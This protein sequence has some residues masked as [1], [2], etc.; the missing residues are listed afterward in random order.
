M[1]L[2]W[3]IGILGVAV[4]LIGV[5]M[6]LKDNSQ[7]ADRISASAI[8]AMNAPMTTYG[9]RKITD[10]CECCGEHKETK[11]YLE[12]GKT[13]REY[14]KVCADSARADGYVSLQVLNVV[15]PSPKPEQTPASRASEWSGFSEPPEKPRKRA[16]VK[17]GTIITL[18]IVAV[19]LIAV[20]TLTVVF[21]RQIS[22]FIYEKT[23]KCFYHQLSF[24]DNHS[25]TYTQRAGDTK[26]HDITRDFICDRCGKEIIETKKQKHS[27]DYTYSVI[28]RKS[29]EKTHTYKK[30]SLC[31]QC[32]LILEQ[33]DITEGHTEF[34]SNYIYSKA[35]GTSH[36]VRKLI[37]CAFCGVF[38]GEENYTEKHSDYT[39]STGYFGSDSGSHLVRKYSYCGKCGETCGYEDTYEQH[40]FGYVETAAPTCTAQGGRYKECS[41]CREREWKEIVPATHTYS[42]LGEKERQISCTRCGKETTDVFA[43]KIRRVIEADY[44]NNRGYLHFYVKTKNCSSQTV[45]EV[46]A[47][48]KIYNS[49]GKVLYADTIMWKPTSF[50]AGSVANF[51]FIPADFFTDISTYSVE[52][53]IVK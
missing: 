31:P 45:S 14:C 25:I 24:K 33:E 13:V 43:L 1:P 16:K 2:L 3:I 32:G 50:A 18:C 36:S 52:Y 10:T 17:K 15:K 21:R 27:T 12:N 8:K 44:K 39:Y 35:D 29:D 22:S 7:T 37:S 53:E 34:R 6:A 19:I 46:K 9:G 30:Q 40:V 5:C 26:Y 4:L 51:E 48:A 28:H 20:A 23:G 47:T 41:K 38:C 42:A 49:K 11:L